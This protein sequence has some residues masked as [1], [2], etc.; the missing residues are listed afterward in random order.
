MAKENPRYSCLSVDG[1]DNCICSL[2]DLIREKPGKCFIEMSACAGSCVGGP[3]MGEHFPV[4]DYIAVSRYAGKRD[5]ETS[6]YPGRELDKKFSSLAPRR[7][8]LGAG[9]VEEVLRKLGKTRPEHELN[10]GSCGYNTCRDK[11]QAVLE[12]K[13]TLTMCL[14]YLK[15]KA[16]S[17]SDTIIGNTPNG[18]IVL[19]ENLEVQQINAAACRLL[20]IGPQ[21]ILGDQVVRVLDPLPFIEVGR[22]EK[23]IYNQRV[24]LADYEKYIDQTIIYDKSY[25][26]IIGIMRDVTGEASRKAAK[27]E[28][29]RKTIEI[30][31]KVI[32]KQM[33]TVQEI[34]SLLGETT[35]ETKVALTKLKESLANE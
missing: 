20:N 22:Q 31:N 1:I 18:I 34:A 27:E 35:A 4:R 26:I 9:A 6:S 29:N 2:E 32:E 16:E 13:A 5:F 8:R 14:P 28:F 33:R 17:F 15:E 3:V 12:G 23:N 21:D 30:T 25:R 10:C 24:Y 7:V 11:A 19:N